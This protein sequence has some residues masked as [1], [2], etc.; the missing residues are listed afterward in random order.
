MGLK[1]PTASMP[2]TRPGSRLSRKERRK[3]QRSQKKAKK[4]DYFSKKKKK[5]TASL[6]GDCFEIIQESGVGKRDGRGI[7]TTKEKVLGAWPQIIVTL[8]YGFSVHI[9]RIYVAVLI[10]C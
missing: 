3:Q 9:M 2:T 5:E 4:A 1:T 10:F 8:I 7:R 6:D